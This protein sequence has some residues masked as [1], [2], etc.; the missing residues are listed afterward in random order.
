[1]QKFIVWVVAN[2]KGPILLEDKISEVIT[3]HHNHNYFIFRVNPHSVVQQ[4]VGARAYCA[5]HSIRDH[6][7]L[8][9][10]SRCPDQ[11]V[12]LKRDPQCLSPRE[13]VIL[14]YRPTT[15]EMKC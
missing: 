11:V 2:E 14:I 12:S 13:S 5:H 4:P 1:M 9:C 6:L 8:R 3:D 15:V 10:M 7:A